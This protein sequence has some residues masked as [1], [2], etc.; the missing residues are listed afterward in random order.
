ML[1]VKKDDGYLVASR[2][3]TFLSPIP[4]SVQSFTIRSS[5]EWVVVGNL[6]LVSVAVASLVYHA[7]QKLRWTYAKL[8]GPLF[9]EPFV[10]RFEIEV[11]SDG[12]F[13]L[14]AQRKRTQGMD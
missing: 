11:D 12:H 8:I 9:N 4:S 10:L 1:I 14:R 6:L 7:A 5:F 3:F 13:L 2:R